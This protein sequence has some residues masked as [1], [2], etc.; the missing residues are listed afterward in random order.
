MA[1]EQARVL[2]WIQVVQMDGGRFTTALVNV[3]LTGGRRVRTDVYLASQ[4]STAQVCL[5]RRTKYF[6]S[7]A[8]KAPTSHNLEIL[9]A[10]PP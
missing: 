7:F 10:A 8:F 5:G 3:L 6:F 9:S 4:T 2:G 1:A